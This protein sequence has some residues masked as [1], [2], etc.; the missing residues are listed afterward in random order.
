MDILLITL[1][2]FIAAL[3]GTVT[4]FGIST[5][6]LPVLLLFIPLTQVLLLGNRPV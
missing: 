2:T 3:L 4:G 1:L 5:I 6:M